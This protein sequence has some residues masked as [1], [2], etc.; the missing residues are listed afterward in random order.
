MTAL[1]IKICSWILKQ[2]FDYTPYV[3]IEESFEH[4]LKCAE[5]GEQ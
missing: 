4:Y 1:K 5:R 2:L 3:V